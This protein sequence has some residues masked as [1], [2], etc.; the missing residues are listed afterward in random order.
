MVSAPQGAA[1]KRPPA[2]VCSKRPS[3][4]HINTNTH[5][6]AAERARWRTHT[7]ALAHVHALSLSPAKRPPSKVYSL[8]SPT[9]SIT[10]TVFPAT[11]ILVYKRLTA[12]LPSL[13]IVCSE[14][15]HALIARAGG[16]ERARAACALRCTAPGGGGARAVSVGAL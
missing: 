11:C 4:P 16:G 9:P 7:W 2:E 5:A 10:R 15:P 6:H 13:R 12:P 14:Q 3:E 1:A 8:S